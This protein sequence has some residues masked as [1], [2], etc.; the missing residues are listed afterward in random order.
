[1]D[2]RADC[3]WTDCFLLALFCLAVPLD[4]LI[5]GIVAA[6]FHEL[7]HVL[8]VLCLGARIYQ[9]HIGGAG[10]V[11]DAAPMEPLREIISILSGPAGSLA[12]MALARYAPK[13]AL[14]GAVQGI[15]NLLP[16]YPLDGGRVL[17]CVTGM[18][19]AP[20]TAAA[21]CNAVRG[22]FAFAAAALALL[23]IFVFDLGVFPVL[24]L[25]FFLYRAAF[26]KFPCNAGKLGV[27]Y[28]YHL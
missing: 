25:L 20:D 26:G 28:S 14:C 15:F 1:M 27:Q 7:C 12:L 6:C 8:A 19:F 22:V 17:R 21:F 23:G 2:I 9:I 11:L 18:V 5:S 16:I 3:S 10:A 13:L 4:W 24:I